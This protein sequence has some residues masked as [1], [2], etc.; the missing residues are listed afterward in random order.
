MVSREADILKSSENL[1]LAQLSHLQRL[2]ENRKVNT[3]S[4]YDPWNKLVGQTQALSSLTGKLAQKHRILVQKWQE[5][6][7]DACKVLAS[8]L[9][10]LELH[11]LY[12]DWLQR[13][14]ALIFG[15]DTLLQHFSPAS[16]FAQAA[17][18]V[19]QR[20]KQMGCSTN[21]PNRTVAD[22]ANLYTDKWLALWNQTDSESL[23][24]D[25]VRDLL[26]H[27]HEQVS[28]PLLDASKIV[29]RGYFRL[30]LLKFGY[31]DILVEL[32]QLASGELAIFKVNSGR[33]PFSSL[34]QISEFFRTSKSPPLRVLGRSLLF[35][36]LR[37]D[38]LRAL[39]SNPYSVEL[40]SKTGNNIVLSL[41]SIDRL[42]WE[43]YWKHYCDGLFSG[44]SLASHKASL[45]ITKSV[46]QSQ[47]FKFKHDKLAGLRPECNSGLGVSLFPG[48]A[49]SEPGTE[50]RVS[51]LLHK[52]KPLK[53]SLSSHVLSKESLKS[54]EDLDC[55][56]LIRLDQDISINDVSPVSKPESY[57]HEGE[58]KRVDSASSITRN[59]LSSGEYT[60]DCESIISSQDNEDCGEKTFDLSS[61]FHRPQLTKKKSSSLLSLFSSNRSKTSLRNTKN[62]SLDLTAGNSTSSLLALPTPTSPTILPLPSPHQNEFCS[63]PEHLDTQDRFQICDH[64]VKASFWHGNSWKAMSSQFLSFKLHETVDGKVLCMLTDASDRHCLKLCAFVSTDWKVSRSAAQDVQLRISNDNI[65]VTSLPVT[66]FVVSL[67][68]LQIEKLI[69]TLH[70]CIRQNLPSKIKASSTCGTL[71]TTSSA[72]S[73]FD[74]SVPRSDTSS[75]GLSS[76]TQESL[77]REKD[78][79]VSLLLLSNIKVRL[80]Q[81]DVKN[82]WVVKSKGLLD[83]YS[84][85]LRGRV[86]A[87]KFNVILNQSECVELKSKLETIKRIGRTGVAVAHESEDYLIEFKNQIVA[88]EVFKLITCLM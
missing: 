69:N 79:T 82:E 22:L 88:N 67:R 51:T 63:L 83:V 48:A 73:A 62:L 39:T 7:G 17:I 41:T 23:S 6:G 53:E 58:Y 85:E 36:T 61:E 81:R 72:F 21:P 60:E 47:N 32:F 29:N 44:S 35:P 24:F 55:E 14:L 25:N 75:T 71:S 42:G 43:N 12:R 40:S 87:M 86:F 54:I 5:A 4:S 1:H 56:S 33:L 74:K 49:Q 64:S 52:S 3:H 15:R 84:Q 2:L 28:P 78:R 27:S 31:E 76:I 46:H 11:E 13:V 77:V 20:L 65:I 57:F 80:H 30:T 18:H 26:S 37:K 50:R 59:E 16:Q 68:C 9:D 34:E 8:W 19:L 38:D 45:G 70:H 10:D 66:S